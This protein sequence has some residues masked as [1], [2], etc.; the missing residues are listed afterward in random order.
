MKEY[1]DQMFQM[2]GGFWVT[3]IAGALATHSIPEYLETGPASAD[4]VAAAKGL[5]PDTTFRLLRACASL[6]LV[7]CDADRRFATTPL[8]GTLKRTVP[9][10]LRGLAMH[11]AAPGVWLPFGHFLTALKTGESQ[12]VNALGLSIWDYFSANPEEGAIFSEAMR[13]YTSGVAKQVASLLD[14]SRSMI[15][16]DVGG[17]SGNL[18]H[19]LLEANFHL[20]GVVF[21]LPGAVKA[22]DLAAAERG[23]SDRSFAVAGDFFVS[24]PE[25]D[26]Y[27][28]KHILHDWDDE[29][30]A[31]ILKNCRAAARPDTRLA[32]IEVLLEENGEKAPGPLFDLQMMVLLNGRERTLE[33][34]RQLLGSAGFEIEKVS[35]TDTPVSLIEAVAV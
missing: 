25:G 4:Q 3:Q 32:I 21:D 22:A 20:R 9:G 19:E 26:L 5:H 24:L 23:L 11:F 29:H 28:L 13:G 14:A 1:F 7:T 31:K 30:A 33:D 17:A 34:F 10:S 12:S 16:V 35:A 6:G 18:L 8:L 27:L 2:L 15:A